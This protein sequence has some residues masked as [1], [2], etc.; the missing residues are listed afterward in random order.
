MPFVHSTSDHHHDLPDYDPKG[1]MSTTVKEGGPTRRKRTHSQSAADTSGGPSSG[2]AELKRH[3][4][5]WFDDGNTVLVAQ[6]TSFKIHRGVLAIHSDVFKNLFTIPQPVEV[7]HVD[8]CPVV[9][10]DDTAVDVAHFL[11]ALYGLQCVYP[12]HLLAIFV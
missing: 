2:V 12:Y 4:R 9:H 5:L 6:Q 1:S 7:E 11:S 8:D 3:E 10:L